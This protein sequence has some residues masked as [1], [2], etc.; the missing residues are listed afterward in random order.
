MRIGQP[1][2]LYEENSMNTQMSRLPLVGLLAIAGWFTCA[3]VARAAEPDAAAKKSFEK[4]LK[5][6]ETGDKE[7]F[8][9]DG[10]DAVKQGTTQE[11]MEGLSKLVGGRMK[12]GYETLYLCQLKQAGHQ[13][14][15][16]KASFKDGG[17]DVVFRMAVKDGKVAGFFIQ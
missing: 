1:N 14:H 15:L 16:W 6:I 8:S 2:T 4:I 5:A 3:L 10:T 9:S 12:G 13:I 7:A 11:I 17:D